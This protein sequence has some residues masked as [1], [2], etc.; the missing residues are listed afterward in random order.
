M[1]Y[2]GGGMLSVSGEAGGHVIWSRGR[3]RNQ[4]RLILKMCSNDFS[5]RADEYDDLKRITVTW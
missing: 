4:L 2:L 5:R 1:A 3:S